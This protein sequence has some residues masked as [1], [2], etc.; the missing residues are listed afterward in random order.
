MAER[1][2]EAG[3]SVA[4]GNEGTLA[5]ERRS[6]SQGAALAVGVVPQGRPTTRWL[7]DWGSGRIWSVWSVF[8][9]QTVQIGHGLHEE[10]QISWLSP[11]ARCPQD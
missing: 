10:R 6:E 2:A 8:S 3:V 7:A 9:A 5:S 11:R 4:N 1:S